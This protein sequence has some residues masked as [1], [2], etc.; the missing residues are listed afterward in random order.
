MHIILFLLC[1]EAIK[2]FFF[3]LFN[4]VMYKFILLNVTLVANLYCVIRLGKVLHS[5]LLITLLA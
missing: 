2:M 1:M 3:V 4:S 5:Y